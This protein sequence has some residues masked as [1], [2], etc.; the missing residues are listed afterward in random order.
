V[1]CYCGTSADRAQRAL[2]VLVEQLTLLKQGIRDDELRRLKTQIR[3]GLIMQQESCRAR[4]NTMASDWFLLG[5]V[6]TLRQTLD[7]IEQLSVDSINNYLA[8]NA[9]TQFELVT[10]GP[11]P[12]YLPDH[13]AL[14]ASA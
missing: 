8:E 2:D 1:I 5:R 10:L 9:P 14:P 13:A 11:E 4:A 3:S 7:Q 6:P 12:L